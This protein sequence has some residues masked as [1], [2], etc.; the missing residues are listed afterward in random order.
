MGKNK[1]IFSELKFPTFVKDKDFM[2]LIKKMLVK[3]PLSRLCKLSL[4]K[5]EPWF[6]DFSWD[7]L[8]LLNLQPPYSPQFPK[9]S[10]KENPTS[11]LEYLK[12]LKE[13]I[14]TKN[15]NIDRVTQAEYNEW[16][17]KF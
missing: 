16:F 5:T 9:G 11:I 3:S 17:K 6:K 13:Y 8:I 2:A 1:I 15:F 14:P 7:N 12:T 10:T 4:I